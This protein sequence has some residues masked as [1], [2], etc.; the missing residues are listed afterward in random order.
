MEIINLR[1]EIITMI[2]SD[3]SKLYQ[4][5]ICPT[6]NLEAYSMVKSQNAT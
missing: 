6:E 1:K 2:N 3:F 4:D 5:P